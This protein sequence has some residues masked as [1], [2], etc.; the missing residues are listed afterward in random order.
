M[1]STY[2][3]IIPERKFSEVSW[4]MIFLASVFVL[5]RLCIQIWKRKMMD[6]QDYL[7]YFAFFCFLVMSICYLITVP[8]AYRLGK[9]NS[10]LV[11]PWPTMMNDNLINVRLMFVTTLLF[12]VSLWSVKLSLL[13]LYRKLIQGQPSTYTRF[14]WA[15]YVFCLVVSNF[16]TGIPSLL[17]YGQS[18]IGC[19]VSYLTSC[20]NFSETLSKGECS[21]ERSVRGQIASLYTAY[22]LDV[23]SDLLSTFGYKDASEH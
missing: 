9:V 6:L 22:A 20:S 10:G 4:S 11:K 23:L 1:L 7:V 17:T 19:I 5:V 16:W 2:R 14:W 21:G 3:D 13:A 15:L 12:W 8:K 18:L